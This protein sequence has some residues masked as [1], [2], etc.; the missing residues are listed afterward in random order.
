[1]RLQDSGAQV[2]TAPGAESRTLHCLLPMLPLGRYRFEFE[3]LQPIK[4]RHYPGSAWR[5]VFGHALKSLVCVTRAPDCRGCMLLHSCAYPYLFETPGEDSE[6][7]NAE[8]EPAPRGSATANRA[9]HPLIFRFES[10]PLEAG[11]PYR[12]GMVL[13]GQATSY[14][15]FAA[16]ALEEAA[17]RGIGS[18]R[19]RFRLRRI[20]QE[21]PAGSGHWRSILRAGRH[22]LSLPA[23]PPLLPA[24]PRRVRIEL[25]SP[26][27]LRTKGRYV[28]AD[29]ALGEFAAS[30]LRRHLMML[31]F[32]GR[33]PIDED[34][35]GLFRSAHAWKP[36][37]QRLYWHDW[38]RY[39]NRQQTK[40]QMG[41]LL[42]EFVADLDGFPEIWPSLH[43]GQYLH[44]GKGA[45]M[46]LGAYRVEALAE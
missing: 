29:G 21:Y 4:S 32:H 40:M 17:D 46:G 18:R 26:L 9:P 24:R 7:P 22:V 38:T 8:S 5:G 41:G 11:S 20:E 2:A 34:L 43:I 31:R 19:D 16:R 36:E 39:S 30:L 28:Q 10:G 14:L 1:M 27:R 13:A 12:V 25:L 15:S 33:K 6:N 42:G 3:A 37:A 45:I 23:V 35:S 44:A